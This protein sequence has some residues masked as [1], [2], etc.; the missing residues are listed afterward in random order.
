[1][2]HKADWASDEA[3]RTNS[4][5]PVHGVHVPDFTYPTVEWKWLPHKITCFLRDFPT[6]VHYARE[7]VSSTRDYALA[8]D[9]CHDVEFE[10]AKLAKRALTLAR[11]TRRKH[12]AAQWNSDMAD[13]D[14][15]RELDE[16]I[17]ASESRRK[18]M[19]ERAKP[20]NAHMSA[21]PMPTGQA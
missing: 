15:E 13:G 3:I 6:T 5:Q 18:V 8:P 4:S 1:M 20:R 9:I 17:A 12:G 19:L 11:L 10:C 14:L 21:D 16:R 7:Y 2:M